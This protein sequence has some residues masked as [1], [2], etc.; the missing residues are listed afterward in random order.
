M[1]SQQV[2]GNVGMYY[3][4]YRLSRMGWNVMPTSRN[5]RGI[6]LLIYDSG[7]HYRGIQVKALSKHGAVPLGIKGVDNLLGNWWIIVNEVANASSDPKC[8]I[9]TPDEVK[10]RA[11]R[12]EH[13]A[14]SILAS[15]QAIPSSRFP[16]RCSPS[17]MR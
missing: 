13:K 8:F 10:N 6:D 12:D 17:P 4:A 5:A 15:G 7:G 3:A 14:R 16:R 11:V 2:T 1:A 9:M